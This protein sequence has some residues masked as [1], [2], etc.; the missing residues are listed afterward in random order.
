MGPETTISLSL[1][2]SAISA[3]G[4]IY[5]IFRGRK[6]DDEMEKQR[7][8]DMAKNFAE[9]NV[10]LTELNNKTA[11]TNRTIEKLDEKMDVMND[12]ISRQDER[13][14]T[15]FKHYDSLSER[16]DRLESK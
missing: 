15:L 4:V 14:S 9:V 10:K 7:A 3:I 12:R 13:I 6:G 5:T 2:I 11:E 1:I 16:V 8:I